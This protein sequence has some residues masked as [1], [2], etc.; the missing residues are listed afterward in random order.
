M[1]RIGLLVIFALSLFL[2][3]GCNNVKNNDNIN[4]SFKE[5]TTKTTM[6]K[7]TVGSLNLEIPSYFEGDNNLYTYWPS[8]N[9]ENCYISVHEYDYESDDLEDDIKDDLSDNSYDSKVEYQEKEINGVKWGYG[10]TTY[11]NDYGAKRNN[12]IYMINYNGKSYVVNYE[13]TMYKDNAKQCINTL[14]SIEKSFKIIQ[15]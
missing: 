4:S 15:N 14:N 13:I 2:I 9:E 3:T 10:T 8:S 6:K 1:K 12:S 5:N 11:L 7:I